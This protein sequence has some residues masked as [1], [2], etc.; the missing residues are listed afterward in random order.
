M[1]AH[2]SVVNHRARLPLGPVRKSTPTTFNAS[3]LRLLRTKAKLSTADLAS[4]SG[5]HLRADVVD[6]YEAGERQPSFD[7]LAEMAA[8]LGIEI[9][10]LL[11]R[12]YATSDHHW[13]REA[14][15][16]SHADVADKLGIHR[17]TVSR[18]DDTGEIAPKH[19]DACADLYNTTVQALT[20]NT[21]ERLNLNL[22][23]TLA[24]QV[25]RARRKKTRE[26]YLIELIAS[27]L[28]DPS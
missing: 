1:T 2:K 9:V 13:Y 12:D 18:W 14:A 11:D 15:G 10:E 7:R 25:D 6:L 3:A 24:A 4:Q 19:L 5:P 23:P 26:Q 22:S 16:L 28:D 8:T 27:A 21:Y 17:S 20:T